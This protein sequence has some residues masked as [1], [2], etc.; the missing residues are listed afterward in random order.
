MKKVNLLIHFLGAAA[1]FN[2]TACGYIK[3][4]FP[5][6]EKDYQYTTEIPELVL[7]AD[8]GKNNILKRPVTT[9]APSSAINDP[10][11]L[12]EKTPIESTA[13]SVTPVTNSQPVEAS[14][15]IAITPIANEPAIVD[16]PIDS[17]DTPAAP[18]TNASA[19]K[20]ELIP[21]EL[22][23]V[24]DGGSRLRLDA[25]FDKAWHAVDKALSRKSVEV[26]SRNKQEN[27]FDI[28][29]NPDE[30]KL[31]DGS[32]WNEALFLFKGFQEDDKEFLVKLID[33]GPQTDV[34]VL[35]TAQQPA[36]DPGA[37]NLLNLL[38]ETIKTDFAK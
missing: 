17:V 26:T 28:H 36:T 19:P 31:E 20:H 9:A 8:L 38:Q 32:L 6:K 1:L 24:A 13:S 18:D 30:T 23:K 4:L 33:N 14:S 37:L 5:D 16:K 7:P 27:T 34:V 11:A 21:V 15:V 25:P 35:D 3:S 2:L 10:E 29:Y 12:T 22:V